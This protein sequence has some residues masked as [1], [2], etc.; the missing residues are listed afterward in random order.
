MRDDTVLLNSIPMFLRR[1]SERAPVKL[2]IKAQAQGV[3]RPPL[4]RP[5][6]VIH[7]GGS[8]V[9]PD[10]GLVAEA[11][12]SPA[13]PDVAQILH[14]TKAFKLSSPSSPSSPTA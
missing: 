14:P 6:M 4:P 3:A 9:Q 13:A 8:P 1:P 5:E 12:I 7:G 2:E 11:E 10:F